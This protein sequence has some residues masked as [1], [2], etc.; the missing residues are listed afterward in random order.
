MSLGS[1]IRELRKKQGLTQTCLGEMVG[2]DGNT[3]SRWE[4]DK[5]GMGNEYVLKFAQAL[6]TSTGYLLGETDDPARAGAS[7]AA[8][9]AVVLPESNVRPF[10]GKLID[11][12]VLSPQSSICCGKGFNLAEVEAE[13]DW[14]E[15]IPES[16]LTGTKGDKPFFITHVEGDSMEPM[17]EDGERILINPNQEVA[18]RDVAIVC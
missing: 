18:H 9:K 2:S 8:S 11:V 12:P 4:L 1:R 16:W 14:W 10:R 15:P 6:D 3:V 17:I 7:Q 5:L 13:V